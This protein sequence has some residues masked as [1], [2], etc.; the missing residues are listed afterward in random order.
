MTGNPYST[1]GCPP[2]LRYALITYALTIGFC[3]AI[4]LILWVVQIVSFGDSVTI[5]LPIG[6][7][8]TT[9]SLDPAP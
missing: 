3:L 8:I 9:I 4:A 2:S 6:L 5:S 1:I 7:S